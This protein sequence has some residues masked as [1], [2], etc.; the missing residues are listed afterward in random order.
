MSLPPLF[1]HGLTNDPR[2]QALDVFLNAGIFNV[3]NQVN[4]RFKLRVVL[5]DRQVS[6]LASRQRPFGILF[7]ELI[8]KNRDKS[9]QKRFYRK[10]SRVG[11]LYPIQVGVHTEHPFSTRIV[12]D[13]RVVPILNWRRLFSMIRRVVTKM[14]R[15]PNDPTRFGLKE[16]GP[17]SKEVPDVPEERKE[18]G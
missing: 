1:S 6:L 7:H 5:S 3:F 13:E 8:A 9:L 4:E 17:R 15:D 16:R 12:D 14:A 11:E 2:V 18:L 10:Q